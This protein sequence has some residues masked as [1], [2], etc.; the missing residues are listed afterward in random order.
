MFF[1]NIAGYTTLEPS[2]AKEYTEIAWILDVGRQAQ[3]L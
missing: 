2:T 1:L 3:Q